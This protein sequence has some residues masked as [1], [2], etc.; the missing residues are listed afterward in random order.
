MKKIIAEIS[1]QTNVT[2]EAIIDKV[3]LMLDANKIKVVKMSNNPLCTDIERDATA[4]F[5]AWLT[6]YNQYLEEDKPIPKLDLANE[7]LLTLSLQALVG[8]VKVSMDEGF[9]KHIVDMTKE[10]QIAY[11]IV[12]MVLI[13]LITDIML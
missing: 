1:R 2:E 7:R 11:S 12:D 9:T 8:V 6:A 13:N 10:E 3:K 4:L 5:T